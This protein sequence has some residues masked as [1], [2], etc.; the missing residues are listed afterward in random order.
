MPRGHYHPDPHMLADVL[1]RLGETDPD[2]L[3]VAL[4]DAAAANA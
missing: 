3:G 4:R 2:H 1:H